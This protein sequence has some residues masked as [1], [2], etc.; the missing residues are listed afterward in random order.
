MKRISYAIV[1][2][3]FLSFYANAQTIN[4]ALRV[5]YPI[6]TFSARALGLGNTYTA[7]SDDAAGVGFNP[8]GLGFIRK[9]EIAGSL[10][11][12]NF[13]NKATFFGNT[14]EYSNSSTDI[15]Q[16]AFVFPFP[17]VRGS[18]VIGLSYNESNNFNGALSFN[19]FNNGD[20]SYIQHLNAMGT[21]V[22]FDLYLTDDNYNT[23]I[24]GKL[25]QSGTVLE[26]GHTRDFGLSV[27][28]EAYRNLFIGGTLNIISGK[29]KYNRDYYEDDTKG[30]YDND[31]LAPGNAF[32][33]DFRTMNLNS[34]LDWE[35]AG[36]DFKLG[37]IY[38]TKLARIGATIQFP[39]S[40]TVKEKYALTGKSTFIGNVEQKLDPD[41][42]SDNVE[43]DIVTPF[44]FNLGA[45]MN[46]M[47]LVVSGEVG[48]IDY[49][50][51]KYDNPRGLT[52]NY[53]QGLNKQ[54][55]ENFKAV[56]DY[57]VGMEYTIK[58]L[59][60]RV[61]AGFFTQNSPYQN[62]PSEYNRTFITGGFGFLID[63]VVAIDF[64]Y[65]YGFWKTYG[66]NYGSGISRTFQ[67]VTSSKLIA[68][69]NYRF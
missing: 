39:K 21:D 49:T 4:D 41:K 5:A 13:N 28:I 27:A 40:I 43:Y 60:M 36:Y 33:R 46:Y 48:L 20:S 50:Q 10:K 19:G 6:K 17:T 29:Y 15:S 18:F 57:R 7:L 16:L 35:I 47:G 11:Y 26:D 69:F 12:D 30:F 3:F 67:D 53:I 23:K 52:L 51:I 42:Y 1:L 66:D 65:A 54:I 55:K 38:Q 62:D 68:S 8:A 14:N 22:P 44:E 37:L 25:N 2:M 59:D 9:L 45:S 31:T 63:Q 56:V 64:T 61:R 32:T 58:D 34:I 24:K